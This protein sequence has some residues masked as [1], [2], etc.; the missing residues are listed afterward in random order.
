MVEELV[1]FG[2]DIEGEENIKA[3]KALFKSEAMRSFS[4]NVLEAAHN[5]S[6]HNSMQ[7]MGEQ[8]RL[9]EMGRY[10]LIGELMELCGIVSQS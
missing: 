3:I 1:V 7:M 8:E 10:D 2:V 5:K 4:E 6:A 9:I